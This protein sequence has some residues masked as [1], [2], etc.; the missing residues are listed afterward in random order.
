MGESTGF[1]LFAFIEASVFFARPGRLKSNNMSCEH[2]L[3]SC[4]HG[5][6]LWYGERDVLKSLAYVVWTIEHGL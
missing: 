1:Y 3:L 4:D 6:L 5:T 2:I